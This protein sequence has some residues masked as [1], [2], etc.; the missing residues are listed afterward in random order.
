MNRFLI[1]AVIGYWRCGAEIHEIE[2]L[3]KLF[4]VII[5]RIIENYLSEQ[6]LNNQ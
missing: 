6:L 2:K 3:T 1:S 5:K 4:P